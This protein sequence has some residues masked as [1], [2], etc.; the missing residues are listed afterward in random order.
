M[1]KINLVA[2]YGSLRKSMHNHHILMNSK[3]IGTF[4][5]EPIYTMYS[6][7]GSYPAIIEGGSTSV[8][9]EIYQVDEAV[10]KRLDQLEGYDE[11]YED[12]D[13]Y[14]SR[15]IL[16]TPYGIAYLYLFNDEIKGYKKVDSGDW[17]QE[18]EN[19]NKNVINLYSEW[20]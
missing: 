12:S 10:Q 6:V 11:Q 13:N 9:M 1:K 16:N 5:S 15:T 18:K 17:V 20:D 19:I 8:L 3:F 4:D 7:G 2:V 14:Y